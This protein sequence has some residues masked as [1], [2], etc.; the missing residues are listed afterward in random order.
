MARSR[1]TAPSG[2]RSATDCCAL[3]AMTEGEFSRRKQ[4]AAMT[5]E[6]AP[7][8]PRSPTLPAKLA[9]AQRGTFDG[10]DDRTA[11]RML[12]QGMKPRDG[13]ASR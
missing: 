11:E 10:V 9:G 13:G 7:V 12:F 8:E 1:A 5:R 2:A 6:A 3:L 4:R